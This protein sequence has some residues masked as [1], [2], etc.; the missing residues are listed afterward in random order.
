MPRAA[1]VVTLSQAN[2]SFLNDPGQYG[3]LTNNRSAHSSIMQA[4]EEYASHKIAT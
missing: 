1:W 3:S 2:L 4:F